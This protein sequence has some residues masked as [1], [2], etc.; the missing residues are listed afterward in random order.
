MSEASNMGQ[1]QVIE[2]D[3]IPRS[4]DMGRYLLVGFRNGSIAEYKIDS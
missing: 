4:L 2:A 3:S 1:I